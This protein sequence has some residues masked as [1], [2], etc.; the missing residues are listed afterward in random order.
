VRGPRL[1]QMTGHVRRK[2]GYSSPASRVAKYPTVL[3]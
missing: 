3:V 2:K 1:A